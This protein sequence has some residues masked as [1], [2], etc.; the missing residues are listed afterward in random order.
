MP[1]AL[2]GVKILDL[3]NWIALSI[4]SRMRYETT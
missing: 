2:E 3:S 1:G 4:D